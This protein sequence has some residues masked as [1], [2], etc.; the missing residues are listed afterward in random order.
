MATKVRL[1]ANACSARAAGASKRESETPSQR[2]RGG[3]DIA[4]VNAPFTALP[5]P[6]ARGGPG[7]P[8]ELLATVPL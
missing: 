6:R 2:S 3:G 4:P 1:A 8:I 7:R 5:V